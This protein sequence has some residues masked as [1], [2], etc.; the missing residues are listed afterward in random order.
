MEF[1]QDTA[2]TPLFV[3][4]QTNPQT[5]ASSASFL[6]TPSLSTGFNFGS[7]APPAAVSGGFNFGGVVNISYLLH[8]FN[9]LIT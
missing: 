5:Y 6:S 3:T 4:S 9:T 1:G 7:T 2:A 8:M